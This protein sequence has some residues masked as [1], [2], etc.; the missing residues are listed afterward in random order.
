MKQVFKYAAVY[1]SR[2]SELWNNF[3]NLP[4]PSPVAKKNNKA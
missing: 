3:E 1:T 4:N 2:I